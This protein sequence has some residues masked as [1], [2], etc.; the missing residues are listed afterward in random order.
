MRR[1]IP[2]VLKKTL[3]A[4]LPAT[5]TARGDLV[6]DLRLPLACI[7]PVI[8]GGV[9][10]R[11][12]ERDEPVRVPGLRGSLRQFWR[13]VSDHPAEDLFR[14]EA[15]L[16]GGVGMGEKGSEARRSR[17]VLSA[18][19][20]DV[21]RLEPAG[22]HPPGKEGGFKALPIWRLG[23]DGRSLGY[24]LFPLQI[25]KEDRDAADPQA[26]E[27]P[28][29]PVRSG[30]RFT[31][32]VRLRS[33]R[34]GDGGPPDD[35]AAAELLAA[36]CALVHFGGVGA[37]QSRGF[38]ALALQE[39]EG[40]EG[41][42]SLE[43]L[44]QR[45]FASPDRD[46]LIEWLRGLGLH[47]GAAAG[48]KEPPWLSLRHARLYCGPA[49]RICE[50][51]LE[52]LV[53]LLRQF[54]QGVGLGRAEGRRQ[55]EGPSHWPE[56]QVLRALREG[57]PGKIRWE[58]P[59]DPA[60]V[61]MARRWPDRLRI[62]RAAFGLPIQVSFKD[63]NDKEAN[64]TLDFTCCRGSRF[65][66]PLWLR[67][68]RCQQGYTSL[69]IAYPNRPDKVRIKLERGGK[70]VSLPV[71]GKAPGTGAPI[72]T[73]LEQGDGDAVTAFTAYLMRQRFIE[74]SGRGT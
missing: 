39:G 28:T 21:G 15:A 69:V 25:E 11:A 41:L 10:T 37:R 66:S 26:R 51:A 1:T 27:L 8:G 74:L 68:L 50:E 24:A 36:L 54:R 55:S 60:M 5:G 70:E 45:R 29:H 71:T 61:E 23:R 46:R 14:H 47:I 73:W 2:S 19:V 52:R 16:F 12:P 38:G 22:Y 4:P 56:P 58:H 33:A 48:Q 42:E 40:V 7:T 6:L 35:Q 17:V 57:E 65:A 31:L 43:A 30:L 49:D 34:R 59:P 62:P 18:V 72:A 20:D 64:A 44:W 32:R 9:E 13:S 53:G 3:D 67:P 63:R